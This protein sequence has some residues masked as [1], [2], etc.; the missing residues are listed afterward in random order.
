MATYSNFLQYVSGGEYIKINTGANAIDYPSPQIVDI[1]GPIY[2]P[3]LYA[4]DLSAMEIASSGG[5]SIAINDT[6]S[7][8]IYESN[9]SVYLGGYDATSNASYLSFHKT[10]QRVKIFGR[11]GLDIGDSGGG[12]VTYDTSGA[13]SLNVGGVNVLTINTSGAQVAGNVRVTGNNL[14][15]SSNATG[16]DGPTNTGAGLRVWGVP[17]VGLTPTDARHIK[18]VTWNH[19]SNGTAD[20]GGPAKVTT[21]SFWELRGGHLRLAHYKD[22][23]GARKI[24]YALRINDKDELE[25]VKVTLSNTVEVAKVIARFG[26]SSNII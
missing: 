20:L 16:I 14:T 17:T 11:S 8:D 7:L 4:K 12:N 15:F 9:N 24:S 1:F 10:Q 13:H 18:S 3:R 2:T 23:A 6:R 21:E 19:G 22:N 5:V 26:V 25:F